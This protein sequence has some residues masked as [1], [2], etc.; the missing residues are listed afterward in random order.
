MNSSMILIVE[1]DV[2]I[3]AI[4]TAYLQNVGFMVSH[5]ENG[6][7]ALAFCATSSPD[8]II[9]MSVCR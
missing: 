5:A 2:E 6:A 9:L 7:L 3:A 8:L 1:D 4:L